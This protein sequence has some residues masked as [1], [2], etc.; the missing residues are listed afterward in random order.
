VS[1]GTGYFIRPARNSDLADM[2]EISKL[3][4]PGFTSLQPDLDYLS[5]LIAKSEQ[6]FRYPDADTSQT[7]LLVLETAEGGQIVGCASIKTGVGSDEFMCADFVADGPVSKRTTLTLRRTLQDYTEVGSL[8]LHPDHRA[9]GAGRYLARARYML[10]ATRPDLFGQPIVS[11]LRGHCNATGHSPFYDAIWL[12][13]LG[14]TYQDTDVLL[15]NEG[16]GF[17]IDR[18]EGL[19][20]PLAALDVAARATVGQPH[21]TARGALRLLCQEGFRISSLIDLSDGG[22]ITLA[23]LNN[24][25]SPKHAETVTVTPGQPGAAG[26]LALMTSSTFDDFCGYVGQL[27]PIDGHVICPGSVTERLYAGSQTA[28]QITRKHVPHTAMAS[29]G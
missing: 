10:M 6:S 17:L 20:V 25:T 7:F 1:S 9:S 24:L 23:Q 28:L 19:E 3:A 14:L 15:A 27:N 16:A 5:A 11:Q 26:A 12:P 18:F 22:P 21:E 4:G 29:L 13:R 2:H 8:F